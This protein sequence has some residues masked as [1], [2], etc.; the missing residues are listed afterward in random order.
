M[1]RHLSPLRKDWDIIKKEIMYKA[2]KAKF[3]QNED[4]RKLLIS[5]QHF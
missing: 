2:V 4:L 5:T 3:E 1:G